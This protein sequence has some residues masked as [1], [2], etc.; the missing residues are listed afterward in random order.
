M[1]SW[2]TI[3]MNY[4]CEYTTYLGLVIIDTLK[5]RRLVFINNYKYIIYV[6]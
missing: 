1:K 2:P 3:I 5:N 6:F 4:M